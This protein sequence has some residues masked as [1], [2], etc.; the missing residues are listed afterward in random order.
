MNK[1]FFQIKIILGWTECSA[2]ECGQKG[3]RRRTREC[4]T[5]YC[6]DPLID[7]ENCKQIECAHWEEW[8]PWEECKIKKCG[9]QGQRIRHR[10]CSNQG[11]FALDNYNKN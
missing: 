9:E 7:E 2:T 10:N 11:L 8:G 6:T 5:G 3:I 4:K 1:I